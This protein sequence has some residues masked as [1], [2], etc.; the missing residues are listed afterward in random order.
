MR[1]DRSEQSFID[2]AEN[3]FG[4]DGM[5]VSDSATGPSMAILAGEDMEWQI[6]NG[7]GSCMSGRLA[8]TSDPNSFD[9]LDDDGADCGSVHLSY[10]SRDGMD[11][12]LYVSH[13]TGDF[14]MHRTNWVPA[15]IEE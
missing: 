4:I 13:E 14:K 12:I 2:G 3:W 6:C 10:A 9:L 15:F 11:G 7:D 5:Y 8:A 1:A